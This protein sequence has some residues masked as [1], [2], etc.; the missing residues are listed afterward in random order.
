MLERKSTH[1]VDN[2]S[3]I[4]FIKT[5]AKLTLDSIHEFQ[6]FSVN[7][8][9][10]SLVLIMNFPKRSRVGAPTL[11]VDLRATPVGKCVSKEI[12]VQRVLHR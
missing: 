9:I 5:Q 12:S 7:E 10:E 11:C 3:L 6:K 8:K 4:L 2:K 1:P